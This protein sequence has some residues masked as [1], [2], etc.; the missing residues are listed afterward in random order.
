LDPVGPESD[1][2]DGVPDSSGQAALAH[3][4]RTQQQDIAVL[5]DELSGGRVADQGMVLREG[6]MSLHLAR[7]LIQQ[8]P[9]IPQ[10]PGPA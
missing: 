2:S 1:T 5:A 8:R 3:A 10:S 7:T 9:H 6:Q 4:R